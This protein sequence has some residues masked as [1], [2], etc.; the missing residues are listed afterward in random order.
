M[1]KPFKRLTVPFSEKG[2][3]AIQELARVRNASLASMVYEFI[4]SNHVQ[5]LTLAKAIEFAKTDPNKAAEILKSMAEDTQND[6]SETQMELK[7]LG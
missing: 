4:D 3:K 5:I 7:D 1:E 6:L 2:Y